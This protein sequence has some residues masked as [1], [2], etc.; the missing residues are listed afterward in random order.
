MEN[1]PAG[2]FNKRLPEMQ[3]VEWTAVKSGTQRA[4][5]K[6]VVENGGNPD[7]VFVIVKKNL[8]EKK[9]G[10]TRQEKE[11]EKRENNNTNTETGTG[12]NTETTTSPGPGMETGGGNNFGGGSPNVSSVGGGGGGGPD[13]EVLLNR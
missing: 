12:T 5:V 10:K 7:D 13:V 11:D 9:F 4:Q 3:Q 1:D 8:P 2:N 6:Q